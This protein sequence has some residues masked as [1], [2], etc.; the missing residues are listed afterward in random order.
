MK[1]DFAATR[2]FFH[3]PRN[4]IYLDGNSLGPLPKAAA[5][6]VQNTIENEWGHMLIRGWNEAGW[7]TQPRKVGDRIARLIGAEAGSVTVGDT[8]SIRVF[9]A[10]SSALN[11]ADPARSIVL[12]DT[13]N[14]PTD[15]YM[16][17][18][19]ITSLNRG[20]T[21][22]TVAPE[23][24]EIM[25]NKDIAVLMLTEVDYR[26]GRKHDM[27]ALTAKAR[28]LGIITIWDLAH[29]AGALPVDLQGVGADFAA[30][31]TYKFLNG[32]PGA[33]AFLYV[34]PRHANKVTPVL[35]GWMGHNDPFAFTPD[36][37]PA[38]GVERMRIGTP[39]VIAMAA[40][41]ASLDIWDH[42]DLDALRAQSI[43]LGNLLISEV[44]RLC[45]SLELVSPRDANHRGSQ[46]S[47]AFHEGYA[48]VQA[49]IARGVIGDFRAP[50]IMRF[51]I[52][53][54]YISGQDIRDAANHIATVINDQLWDAPQFLMRN[55]VT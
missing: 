41:E 27:A 53:P 32:G 51:G 11:L 12:S 25:L 38:A 10:L 29:S 35:P 44:E 19:L 8:L 40:L 31:C 2:N 17:Q 15:L 37:T 4:I 36:Y 46:V 42:V 18:G 47:F 43:L 48:A 50:N 45:P 22:N 3:L 39:P 21:L 24:V 33:P 1:M 16:A 49:L 54:L 9:Q 7:F 14:F 34:A 20:H 26:T 23:D 30:G 5:A 6:R 13:G 28:A 52:C 55:A